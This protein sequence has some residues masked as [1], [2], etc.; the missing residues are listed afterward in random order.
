MD[1]NGYM[2]KQIEISER[3]LDAM[4]IDFDEKDK[5]ILTL[6]STVQSLIT[7]LQERDDEIENLREEIA[8]WEEIFDDVE[9]VEIDEQTD[10]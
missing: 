8:A 9:V 3:L 6:M 1:V 4:R 10:A 2:E 7:K 5:F